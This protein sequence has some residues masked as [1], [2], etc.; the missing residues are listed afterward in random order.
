MMR[1]IREYSLIIC[2]AWWKWKVLFFSFCCFV[3]GDLDCI[4]SV[5]VGQG[6]KQIIHMI[7][8]MNCH[9]NQWRRKQWNGMHLNGLE[10]GSLLLSIVWWNDW[11]KKSTMK[12]IV[13][14]EALLTYNPFFCILVWQNH[15]DKKENRFNGLESWTV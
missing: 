13:K 5:V 12:Y 11:A 3:V 1:R 2:F 6:L 14:E 9:N 4:V 7:L 8:P 15:N 10:C